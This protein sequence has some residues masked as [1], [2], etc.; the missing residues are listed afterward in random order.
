MTVKILG[1]S[2]SVARPSRTTALVRAILDAVTAQTGIPGTLIELA[3]DAPHIFSALTRKQ[4]AGRAA[5]VVRA[6]ETADLLVVATP[7]YRASYTGALKHLFDLADHPPFSGKP[8]LLAATGGTKLH[9]LVLEHQLRPLFGFL[10]ALTLPTTVYATEDDYTDFRLANTS[11]IDRVH[12]AAAEAASQLSLR[13]GL[14]ESLRA[15]G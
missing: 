5:A 14:A 10:N 8:V 2:G 7:V 12:R 9:G 6:V 11:V 1:L 4:L 3:D 15:A 13:R